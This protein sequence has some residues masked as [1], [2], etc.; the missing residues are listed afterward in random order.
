MTSHVDAQIQARIA[1]ATNKRQQQRQQRAE[2][3]ANRQAGLAA[4]KKA[5]L[6]RIY[7]GTCAKPQRR[8]TYLRC[9]LGCGAAVCRKNPH[10]GNT[11][12]R[13]CDNRPEA[14]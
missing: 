6:R 8:G 4:R 3:D 1:A 9:P 2:L 12:L 5:K 13:Q 11:H 10:C 14:A 7:C